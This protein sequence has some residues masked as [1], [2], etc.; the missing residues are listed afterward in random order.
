MKITNVT[1]KVIGVLGIDLMPDQSM[2]I[3]AKN[4][5]TPS[6][7]CLIDMG[8][9][10]LDNSAEM[11]HAMENAAMEEARK[12]VMEELRAAGKLKEDSGNEVEASDASAEEKQPTRKKRVPKVPEVAAE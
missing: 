1:A 10:A 5:T 4:A 9:L 3:S 6:I 2:D 12:K 7:K 11:K 8:L